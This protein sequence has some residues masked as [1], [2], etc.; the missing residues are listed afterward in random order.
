MSIAVLAKILFF[1][2]RINKFSDNACHVIKSYHNY[3]LVVTDAVNKNN[4]I[5]YINKNIKFNI[6]HTLIIVEL[7][8]LLQTTKVLYKRDL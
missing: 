5:D 2:T 7:K 6:I 4:F 1:E 3:F 8:V